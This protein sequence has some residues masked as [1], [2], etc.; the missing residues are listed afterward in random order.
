MTL[1]APTR[2]R[3]IGGALEPSE[4]LVASREAVVEEMG[5]LREEGV[6]STFVQIKE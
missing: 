6:L 1:A 4:M 3:V 2:F 5:V